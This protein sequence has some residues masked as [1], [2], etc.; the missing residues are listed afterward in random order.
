[1]VNS[2]NKAVMRV[3]AVVSGLGHPLL[4]TAVFAVGV[5]WQRLP[6]AAGAWAV[7]SVLAV[8][9]PVGLWSWRQTRRGVYSNFDVSERAQRHSLYPVLLGLLGAATAALFGLL[10]ASEF[11]YGLLAAW[12]MLVLCYGI[13]AWL[14]VSLHAAVSFFLAC[15][16]LHLAGSW[17]WLALGLAAAVA[18]SRWVLGRHTGPELLVGTAVGLAG[19]GGLGWFLTG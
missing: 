15:V 7:G 1:M 10:Q 13:N 17:G 6:G 11:G 16:V 3:A 4:T 12:L 8:V 9:V 5:A 14:K 18:A 19:G 2:Q